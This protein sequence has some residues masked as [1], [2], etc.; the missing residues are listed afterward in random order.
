MKKG[1]MARLGFELTTNRS[2]AD[3]VNHYTIEACLQLG[4]FIKY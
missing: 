4:Q 2:A 3:C 1:L